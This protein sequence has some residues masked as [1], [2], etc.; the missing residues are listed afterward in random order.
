MENL[1]SE[2]C[3]QFFKD[4]P[5]QYQRALVG[6]LQEHERALSKYPTWPDDIVKCAAY[7]DC[8]SGEALKAAIKL[9]NL[10]NWGKE[11]GE[12]LSMPAI[13]M[14]NEDIQKHINN[15]NSEVIQTGAMALRLKLYMGS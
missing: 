8:E 2:E 1:T 11:N 12:T 3:I 5:V 4:Q 14:F 13:R 9:D 10:K 6:F 15:L 7:M